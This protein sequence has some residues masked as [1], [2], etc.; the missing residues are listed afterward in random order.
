MISICPE[1]AMPILKEKIHP[2]I[3]NIFEILLECPDASV[4]KGISDVL[5]HLI[6]VAINFEKIDF[7]DDVKDASQNQES[8]PA[9]N[10]NRICIKQIL[11]FLQTIF[12]ND[13]KD[14]SYKKLKGFF[15]MWY[16]LGKS[17][18]K[19]MLWLIRKCKLADKLYS[20]LHS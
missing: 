5:C 12:K 18:T 14:T 9:S 17:N 10:Q 15:K 3:S 11:L 7:D 16:T 2:S 1:R 6:L 13:K 4:K 19:L 20:T 8:Q